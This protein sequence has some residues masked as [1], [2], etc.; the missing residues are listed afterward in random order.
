MILV[1][2]VYHEPN[3]YLVWQNFA[4]VKDFGRLRL[5]LLTYE[6]KKNG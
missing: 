1:L 3:N 5:N 6:K 2:S 4:F